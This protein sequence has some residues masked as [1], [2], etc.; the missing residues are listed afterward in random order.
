MTHT[1]TNIQENTTVKVFFKRIH[2][3]ITASASDGG[4]IS[5]SGSVDVICGTSK[6]FFAYPDKCHEIDQWIVNGEPVSNGGNNYYSIS[7][8]QAEGTIHVTFKIK[9][10]TVT[11]ASGSG[12]SISPS[13]VQT[14]ACGDDITFTATP[15]SCKEVNQWIV[16]GTAFQIGETICTLENVQVNTTV[17]VTFK[18][19]IHTITT[20][21][22]P[23][24]GGV[25]TGGGTYDCGESRFVTATANS[26][27]KFINWTKN[28]TEVSTNHQYNF[29]VTEDM[30]LVANFKENGVSIVETQGIASPIQV[31]PNPTDGELTIIMNDE[32]GIMNVEYTIHNIIGQILMQGTLPPCRD[33]ARN[34]SIINVATLPSGMYFLKVAGQMVKF[35]RE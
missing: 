35:V 28:G 7:N 33:V 29:I 31:Y 13:V 25:A 2:H 19:I 9:T 32:L 12:G 16:N 20:S 6:I 22:N 21:A 10:Y 4:S 23:P 18:T 11:P 26:G 14:I 34:V 5:P 1:V 3:T 24:A 27:Y 17:E 15:N 8:V 30:E